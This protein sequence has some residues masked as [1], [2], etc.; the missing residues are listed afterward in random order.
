MRA[1]FLTIACFAF[2]VHFQAAPVRTQTSHSIALTG[3]VSS[4]EEGQMEGV[5]VSAKKAASTMTITVVSDEQGQYRFPSSKLPP[6]Q[7]ALRIRAVGYDLDSPN[8]IEVGS[9]KTVAY[10]LKLRKATDPAAQLS[11][12]EWFASLP[13]TE[14]Q[15]A[16]VRNCGHCHTR[17]GLQLRESGIKFRSTRYSVM[18][19]H[20]VFHE[21][22]PFALDCMGK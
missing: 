19:E 2:L 13:G 5:L 21:A 1:F 4:A 18:P 12:A 20:G 8:T 17:L 3:R 22:D 11:N 16:S 14:Q 6:G 10:D 7:Y 15:K 9:G